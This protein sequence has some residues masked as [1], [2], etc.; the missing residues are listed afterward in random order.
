[1]S[2]RTL[3]AESLRELLRP[4]SGRG[5]AYGRLAASLRDSILNGRLPLDARL[6]GER[7]LA[8]ALG[9]SRTTVT[10]AYTLLRDEGFVQVRQGQ[11]GTTSL[12]AGQSPRHPSLPGDPSPEGLLDLAYATPAAPEQIHRAY[13]AA[14]SQLPRFLPTHGY[15]P[16]GLPELRALI[17]ERYT[18]RGTPTR[19][20][21]IIVTFGAQHALSLV[22]Q[23]LTRPGE[24]VL[25]EWPSYPHALDAIRA[26]GCTLVPVPMT[27][28]GWDL[29]ALDAA[30]RQTSPRLAYLIPD[31]QNPTGFRMPPEQRAGLARSARS[32]TLLVLDETLA[33]LWLDGPEPESFGDPEALALGSLSKS[34]W[35]GLR[36]GWV[37]APA[38]VLPRL[39]AARA[40]LDLGTPL[41]EQLAALQLLQHPEAALAARREGLRQGRAVLMQALTEHLPDWRYRVPTGGLSLWVQLPAP[42]S[43][44]LAASSERFGVR[45]APGERFGT[46]GQFASRLRLPYTLDAPQLNEA[47]ARLARTWQALPDEGRRTARPPRGWDRLA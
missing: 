14:L 21:Q 19:A 28:L 29:A 4:S 7:E 26:R 20:E 46:A 24:R 31:F 45:V 23:A 3:S 2:A 1:M 16:L 10:A 11:R 6:P 35:G 17:A 38:R 12:P 47:V 37:R 44:A 33:D 22:L 27:E 18:R 41:L 30:L 5:S 15:A 13:A 39:L 8:R 25:V 36:L 32:R 42:H 43:A 9:L 34:F 40:S